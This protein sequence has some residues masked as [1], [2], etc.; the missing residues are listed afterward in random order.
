M[1]RAEIYKIVNHR[2]PKL[3]LLITLLGIVGP[4]IALIFY[5]PKTPSAY[6]TTYRHVY[7]ILPSVVAVAF[8]GWILGTEYRQDTL[9]RILV[10]EP[11]RARTLV[12]KAVTGLATLTA[13][14]FAIAVLGWVTARIV[15][16]LNDYVVAWPGREFLPGALFAIGA[17]SVA[18]ALSAITKSDSLAMVATLAL[19]L[20]L[21]PLLAMIPWVGRFTFGGALETLTSRAGGSAGGL[22]DT[23]LLTNAQASITLAVWLTLFLGAAGY[24]FQSRDL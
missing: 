19:V 23:S 16:A 11:R 17:A 18:F 21:D 13:A 4:S 2:L 22:F 3:C 9:K 5:T 8:G 14:L 1:L 7:E 10:T 6:A 12:A 15:G 24:L 20:I